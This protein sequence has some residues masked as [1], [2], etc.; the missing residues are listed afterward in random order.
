MNRI[1]LISAVALASF[2]VMFSSVAYCGGYDGGDNV[3]V[4]SSGDFY[5][6]TPPADP[7]GCTTA[8][9]DSSNHPFL[10]LEGTY[11]HLSTSDIGTGSKYSADTGGGGGALGVDWIVNPHFAVRTSID[12]DYLASQN[13][14]SVVDGLTLRAQSLTANLYFLFP[15][16]SHL[17][18]FLGGGGGASNLNA[19]AVGYASD[20]SYNAAWLAAAGLQLKDKLVFLEL[21]YR[22]EDFGS[23]SLANNSGSAAMDVQHVRGQNGYLRLGFYF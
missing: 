5:P 3:N 7:S 10:A 22:Y 16:T 6:P 12:Y 18:L 19:S 9:C 13:D 20:T 23:I 17:A 11:G 8:S 15:F 2:A 1:P 14:D 21:G 4:S